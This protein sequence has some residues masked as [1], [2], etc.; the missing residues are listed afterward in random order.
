M[1]VVT[2]HLSQAQA[3]H[4]LRCCARYRAYAWQMVEP[5]PQRNQTM[6][7]A[8]AMQ[9]RLAQ[10][11]ERAEG[12]MLVVSEEEKQAL[13][14]LVAALMQQVTAEAPSEERTQ[15]LG[16]LAYLRSLLVRVPGHTQAW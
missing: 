5:G 10:M 7:A 2:L 8:Q 9:G 14:A 16:T 11:Q 4:L 13:R 1:P 12:V 6:K 3:N 15:T